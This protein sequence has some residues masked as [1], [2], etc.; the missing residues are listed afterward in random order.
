VFEPVYYAASPLQITAL[1]DNELDIAAL[2]YSSFPLAVQNAG[3]TD[4]RILADEIQD[5]A[6]GY[7]STPYWVRKD[8]GISRIED[9]KCKVVATNGLGSGVDIIMRSALH[10]HGL[11]DKRDC[12]IIEAPFPTHKAVLKDR[13]ADLIV[14]AL[15]FSYDPEVLEMAKILFNSCSGFGEVALSFRTACKPFVDKN[16]AALVDL[17]EDYVVASRW[18]LDPAKHNEAAQITANFLKRPAASFEGWLFTNRDFYRDR[19]GVPNLKALQD[20]IDKVKD[21]GFIK[22]SLEVAPFARPHPDRGSGEPIALSEAA[23]AAVAARPCVLSLGTWSAWASRGMPKKSI[24][25]SKRSAHPAANEPAVAG[26]LASSAV[27]MPRDGGSSAAAATSAAPT[28]AGAA[29]SSYAGAAATSAPTRGAAT[30]TAAARAR[31][32]ACRGAAWTPAAARGHAA[33]AAAAP[34]PILRTH[35]RGT[36]TKLSGLRATGELASLRAAAEFARLAA[37]FA[38]LAAAE[39]APF[40]YATAKVAPVTEVTPLVDA[41]APAVPT[42]G[43]APAEAAAP[44]E[45]ALVPAGTTPAV[46]VPAITPAAPHVLHIVDHGEIVER[47]AHSIG[48]ADRR[49]RR[50]ACDRTRAQRERGDKSQF[51]SVHLSSPYRDAP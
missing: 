43:P 3:L 5:G 41:E 45:A 8:S 51:Q 44:M 34:A 7:Y 46:V 16:R 21:L 18:Y 48:R 47:G 12:T 23:I 1:T 31:A 2:G 22:A 39:A 33:A 11:G 36:A 49:A 37:E 20:N 14:T 9:L 13:N 29:A 17:L 19:N 4:L 42:R 32:S 26:G 25:R 24:E 28:T 30:P 6:P 10:R 35:S 15:P 27:V 38:G 50:S 40:G